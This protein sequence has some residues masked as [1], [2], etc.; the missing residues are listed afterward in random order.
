MTAA[1][2]LDDT[3]S[4]KKIYDTLAYMG[5]LYANGDL[6]LEGAPPNMPGLRFRLALCR[7]GRSGNKPFCDNSRLGPGFE[8][9]G[10]VGEKGDGLT[11]PGGKLKIKPSPDGPLL[12]SGNFTKGVAFKS[13]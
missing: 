5:P 1:Q 13:S 7:C 9:Y 3:M 12:F 2:R 6:E 4:K 8:D 10:A 11:D